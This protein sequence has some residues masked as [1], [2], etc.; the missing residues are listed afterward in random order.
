MRTSRRV[1]EL[2]PDHQ[3]W[4]TTLYRGWM[5]AHRL[6]QA[7]GIAQI[8]LGAQ[9]MAHGIHLMLEAH[10]PIGPEDI[11]AIGVDPRDLTTAVRVTSWPKDE[12]L[13][14]LAINPLPLEFPVGLN[15]ENQARL[16]EL[17]RAE[18]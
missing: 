18:P 4:V 15:P 2:L 13:A 5:A 8:Q 17:K 7:S 1:H 10:Y 6:G 9:Y 11:L 16:D 12:L 14:N 3:E